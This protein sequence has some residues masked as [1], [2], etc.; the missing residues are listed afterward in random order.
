MRILIIGGTSAVGRSLKMALSKS[1]QIVTA[2]RTGCDI[3]LDLKNPVNKY[4]LPKGFDVIIHTAAQ[5]G[6]HTDEEILETEDVNV[7]GTLK[8]CQAAVQSKVGHLIYISSIFS[9]AGVNSVNYNFY[10]LS[11]KQAEEVATLYCSKHQ[12][13]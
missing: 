2:G 3:I 10:S 6:I 4:H 7:L 12:V 9:T 8:L 13:P 1:F 5:F 11:K